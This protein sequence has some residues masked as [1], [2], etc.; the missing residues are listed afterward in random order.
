V[1][2]A[3]R[4]GALGLLSPS[5]RTGPSLNVVRVRKRFGLV[6]SYLYRCFRKAPR[7]GGRSA[8]TRS[9]LLICLLRGG[10]VRAKN[11]I[12]RFD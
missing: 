9:A 8:K 5:K 7:Q 10:N 6:N 12:V 3:A 2:V 1:A 11:C 4:D